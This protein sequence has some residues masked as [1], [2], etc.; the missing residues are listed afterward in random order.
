MERSKSQFHRLM[1][2]DRCIRADEHPNCLTFAR[3]WEVSQKTVQRDVDFLRDQLG[4]PVVYDKARKGFRYTNRNWFLPSLSLGEGDLFDLLVASRALEQYRGTPVARKL[5]A[6]FSRLAEMMPEQVTVR[7]ELVFSQFSFTSPP[8][9]PVDEKIWVSVVRGLQ[10]RLKVRMRYRSVSA[11]EARERELCPYHIANLQGDWYVYGWDSLRDCIRQFAMSRIQACTVTASTFEIPTAFDPKKLL[12]HTFSRFSMGATKHKVRLLF[13]AAVAESVLDRQWHA[14][15]KL[16][17]RRDGRIELTFQLAGL[18]E[19]YRWV[20]A[21][22]RH[23]QVLGPD[24]LLKMVREEV[25]AMN[26]LSRATG[27]SATRV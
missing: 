14:D 21:W 23:V 1:E 8:A 20:M 22:G 26:R 5:G 18:Q 27:T 7:P 3:A 4:A 6:I 10:N 11:P 25:L 17:I 9:R 12:A 13:A 16:H 19:V 15:Q 2:L 24:E